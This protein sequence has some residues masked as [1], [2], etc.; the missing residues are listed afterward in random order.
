MRGESVGM[1]VESAVLPKPPYPV[2]RI[3]W[4]NTIGG[5]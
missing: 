4:V 5:Y 2:Q 3:A 1:M